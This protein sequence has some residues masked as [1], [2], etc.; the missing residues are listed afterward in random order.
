[1][2]FASMRPDGEVRCAIYT[3]KSTEHGLDAPVN[4]LE[5]QREVCEAYIKCQAHR[6]WV[7]VPAQYDDGG[8]SGGSLDRPAL[9]RMMV[10][11]ENGRIDVVVIY[12]IDRLTRSLTD[13][14]RLLDVLEQFGASFVS[15]TQT[16]DTSDSMGRLVL[17]ILLTFAQFERELT[18]ER[19]K[20]KFAAMKRRGLFAGGNPPIGYC[21]DGKRLVIDPERA[22]W[23]RE[24]FERYPYESTSALV[25]DLARRGFRSRVYVTRAG[26]QKGGRS[27]T[28]GVLQQMLQ[29]P[30]YTGHIVH[31]GEWIAAEIE[32][33]VTREHWELVQEIRRERFPTRRDP[34]HNFL[35]GILHDELGRGMRIQAHGPGRMRDHRYYKSEHCGWARGNKMLP[36][37][38]VRADPVERLARSALESLLADRQEV[39]AAVVTLGLYSDEIGKLLKRGNLGAS[40]LSKMGAVQFRHAFAA[41]VPRAELRSDE[42]IMYV[43]CAELCRFLRWDGAGLFDKSAAISGQLGERVHVLRAAANLMHGHV[44]LPLPVSPC[45]AC[46]ANPELVRLL[47]EATEAKEAMLARRT[48]TVSEIAR[49]LG[50]GPNHFARLIRI[51]YLAP[52]IQAAIVSGTQPKTLTKRLMLYDTLPLDWNQQRKLFGFA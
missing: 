6:N 44:R 14:V 28:V 48:E 30:I 49:G 29:N 12:K 42:L 27:P 34:N 24:V 46:T 41:L 45:E 38:M 11:I 3:R 50:M 51:N 4:S 5:M 43:S 25:R 36:R 32:A 18:S 16:F 17:N 22:A 52:D 7:E 39:K 37:I 40:R 47:T 31:R 13:F 26:K 8:Y 2:P 23:V 35:L 15:V 33:I 19:M 20:D 10:D 1:M 9:K 21:R